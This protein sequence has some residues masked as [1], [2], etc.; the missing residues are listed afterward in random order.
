MCFETQ[1]TK[2]KT[3]TNLINIHFNIGDGNDHFNNFLSSE[4][5]LYTRKL[6]A[7]KLTREV[8]IKCGFL[9]NSKGMVIED[10]LSLTKSI[11][12]PILKSWVEI[13]KMQPMLQNYCMLQFVKKEL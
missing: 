12:I 9:A 5:R 8:V 13:L 2:G 11:A 1:W 4:L 6:T 7:A 10:L 3:T